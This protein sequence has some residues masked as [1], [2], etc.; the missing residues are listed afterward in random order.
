MHFS[1]PNY[2]SSVAL[3]SLSPPLRAR[4]RSQATEKRGRCR[5]GEG[6]GP[7]GP[8]PAHPLSRLPV[9]SFR[10]TDVRAAGKGRPEPATS[11]RPARAPGPPGSQRKV[12]P[13]TPGS[14]R[15]A[16]R[17]SAPWRTPRQLPGTAATDCFRA[18]PPP[19]RATTRCLRLAGSAGA[20]HAH[21]RASQRARL[22]LAAGRARGR[23]A[24]TRLAAAACAVVRRTGRPTAQAGPRSRRGR[25][26]R[27]GR[28][29]GGRARGGRA[30]PRARG[31]GEPVT[32]REPPPAPDGVGGRAD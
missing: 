9:T 14:R 31:G 32:L 26:C 16:A 30:V 12:V 21:C 17:T 11:A 5:P 24:A 22:R 3:Q 7:R 4:G 18:A 1:A 27:R 28:A 8:S 6:S 2:N 25:G 13:P 10:G 15:S 20:A 23:R 19:S 29:A